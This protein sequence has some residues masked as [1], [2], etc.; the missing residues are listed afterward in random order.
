MRSFG[1]GKLFAG[2]LHAEFQAHFYAFSLLPQVLTPL[3]ALNSKFSLF[4][5]VRVL[6]TKFVFLSSFCF[7]L[8]QI[9]RCLVGK[10]SAEAPL[11][12]LTFSPGLLFLRSCLPSGLPDVKMLFH[13]FYGWFWQKDYS[14]ICFSVIAGSSFPSFL[15][16]NIQR[17][18]YVSL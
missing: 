16:K 10:R 8:R 15:W 12:V 7:S 11:S 4:S 3:A 17:N 1:D 14:D 9:C 6:P 5:P 2:K 18:P 13:A